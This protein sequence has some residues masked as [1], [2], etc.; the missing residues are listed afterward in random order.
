MPDSG[1]LIN[2]QP[3]DHVKRVVPVEHHPR[4]KHVSPHPGRELPEMVPCH[5]QVFNVCGCHLLPQ[6][7]RV[8]LRR[9]AL[10]GRGLQWQFLVF[11]YNGVLEQSPHQEN[12]E[13]SE[14]DLGTAT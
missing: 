12:K 1:L 4:P 7:D 10:C 2:I 5:I 6:T 9:S 11:V 3:R 13:R 14:A 8:A